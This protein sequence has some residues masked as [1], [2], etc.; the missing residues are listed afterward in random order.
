MRASSWASAVTAHVAMNALRSRR[1]ERNVVDRTKDG[2]SV[3]TRTRSPDDV[4]RQAG[5]RQQL[6][7][8]R[9]HLAALAPEKAEALLLHDV[10]GH[11]LAEI[12][13][14]TG[15]SVAAAQSRLVRGRRELHQR[16]SSDQE[17]VKQ[18]GTR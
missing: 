12:S 7:R 3:S 1:R 18:E 2:D 9:G 4:E 17:L 14:L 13:V 15:V 5:A 6:D 8:L 11:E 10:L 16:I